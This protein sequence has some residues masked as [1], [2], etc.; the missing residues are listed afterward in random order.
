VK[1]RSGKEFELI[2]ADD[3]R[4]I[5]ASQRNG[6]V[7]LGSRLVDSFAHQLGARHEVVSTSQGT[8]HRLMIPRLS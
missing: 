1:G 5:Q 7:G 6:H 8:E 4:G 2:V 3:G